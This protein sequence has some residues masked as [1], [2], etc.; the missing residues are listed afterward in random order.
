[1]RSELPAPAKLTLGL[2][3]TGRRDDGYH[4]IDAEMVS[5]DLHDILTIDHG[6]V[7]LSVVGPCATGVPLDASN[8]VVRALRFVGRRAHVTIDKR[9]PHGGGLG[10][11]SADAAAVLRWAG[12]TDPTAAAVIGADVAFCLVGGRAR[13]RGIGDII[14]PLPYVERTVTLVVPPLTVSTPAAYRAWDDLGGPTVNGP[15]DL[16]P[17]AV[18]VVPELALWRDR[19]EELSGQRP[20]LAGSGA[21]WFVHGQHSNALAGLRDEGAMV[22]AAHTLP[23]AGMPA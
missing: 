2:R 13:V 16:E 6:R 22:V 11:G 9:I 18:A 21:T 23:A 8:L 4:L 1:M 19:I 14:D 20:I 15:N 5:L 17:A 3:I 7:G 12:V 10:G